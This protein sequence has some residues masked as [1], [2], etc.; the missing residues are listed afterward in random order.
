[1]QLVLSHD[2]LGQLSCRVLHVT[3]ISCHMGSWHYSVMHMR[4][5]VTHMRV[6]VTHMR[7]IVTHMRVTVTHMRVIVTHM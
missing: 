7:V 4:V 5:I 1:M 3:L 6:I 2:A